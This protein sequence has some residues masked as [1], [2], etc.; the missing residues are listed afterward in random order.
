MPLEEMQQQKASGVHVSR[1][2]HYSTS[3]TFKNSFERDFGIFNFPYVPYRLPKKQT[4]FSNRVEPNTHVFR[5][6]KNFLFNFFKSCK[7]KFFCA[8]KNFNLCLAFIEV[9]NIDI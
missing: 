6:N 3:A 1:I 8:V 9:P 4:L 2:F 7:I 5:N